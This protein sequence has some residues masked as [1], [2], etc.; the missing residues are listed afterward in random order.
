M[1]G[2]VI[3]QGYGMT[4]CSPFAAYNH[5]VAHRA[6]SVGSPIQH[7]QMKV[8]TPDGSEADVGQFGEIVIQGPNVMAGY[9]RNPADTNMVIRNGWLHTGD[10]GYRDDQDYFFVVDRLKDMI[11]VAGFKVWPR[12]VEDVLIRHPGINEVAVVGVDSKETGDEVVVAVI[13]PR[14]SVQI[15]LEDISQFCAGRIAKYKIPKQV[16]CVA[17][18]PKSPAGKI[19]KRQMRQTLQESQARQKPGAC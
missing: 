12:E 13:V 3:N 19:L 7:V 14:W 8:V 1:S 15:T 17:N 11:N 6:G 4:E 5:D 16:Q 18:L 2:M 9:Y 10:L